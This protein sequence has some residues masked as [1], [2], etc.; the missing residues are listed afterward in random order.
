MTW[1]VQYTQQARQDLRGIQ[2]YI[3]FEL[4]SPQTAAA[5]S[6]RILQEIR[7]L[8]TMPRRYRLYPKEPWHSKGLRYFP[9]N[10][11]L[12]FYLVSDS[13]RAVQIVR[14]LHG[15]RD[16]ERDLSETILL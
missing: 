12:V 13:R 6:G 2:E 10:K 4:Q 5:Q 16:V 11:Y 1:S 9:V 7:A 3:A 14:I 15:S 8:D